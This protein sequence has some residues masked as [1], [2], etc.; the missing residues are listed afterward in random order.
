LTR[1]HR[2]QSG[3]G[4]TRARGRAGPG[5]PG[6]FCAVLAAHPA[7]YAAITATDLLEHLSKPEVLRTFDDVAAA[8]APGCVFVGRVPNAVSPLGGHIRA[9]GFTH[10]TSITACAIP[11]T[12]NG[13][14]FRLGPQALFPRR[15]R[16]AR[17]A[18]A[19][20]CQVVSAC[21]RIG[22]ATIRLGKTA[23]RSRNNYFP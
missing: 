20:V 16:L 19:V 14:R 3:T 7:H 10:Q 12:R 13:G 9:D 5:P 1:R 21:Y 2:H 8:L 22:R 18:R 11:P 6:D 23:K 15:S 17:A 4:G